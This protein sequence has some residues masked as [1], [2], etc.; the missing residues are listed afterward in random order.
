MRP[1]SWLVLV[2]IAA[3]D[4]SSAPAPAPASASAPAAS[5]VSLSVERDGTRLGTLVLPPGERGKLMLK[6]D[7]AAAEELRA[8]WES[9]AEKDELVV[10]MHVE[11]DEGE[12][13]PL[14][15]KIY[16]RGD[17]SYPEGV[18]MALIARGYQVVP[19]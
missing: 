4:R 7:T 5:T 14:G 11:G 2:V 1:A 16:R 17:P 10:E 8:L 12:R 3:C 6:S 15:A 18:R 9:I 19:L 13:G